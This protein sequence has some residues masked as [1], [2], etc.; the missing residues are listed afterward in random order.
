ML[1]LPALWEALPAR[2]HT[3]QTLPHLGTTWSMDLTRSAA[4]LLHFYDCAWTCFAIKTGLGEMFL[5]HQTD[6]LSDSLSFFFFPS[7]AFLQSFRKANLL[8]LMMLDRYCQCPIKLG[9]LAHKTASMLK[10]L[11]TFNLQSFLM[12]GNISFFPSWRHSSKC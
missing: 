9:N 12:H 5:P 2:R 7:I 4:M 10:I 11:D 8:L 1:P 6:I 3:A